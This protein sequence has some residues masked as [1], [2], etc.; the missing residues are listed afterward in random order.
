MRCYKGM[1]YR[2]EVETTNCL[3][4]TTKTLSGQYVDCLERVVI[5]ITDDPASIMR[6]FRVQAL[7]RLG[8][9]YALTEGGGGGE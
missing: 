9:G 3:H 2:V 8:P 6:M 4:G 7:E 5:V 1:A